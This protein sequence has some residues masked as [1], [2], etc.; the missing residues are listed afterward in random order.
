M[1]SIGIIALD[2]DGT[3]LDSQK[4]LSGRNK[5]ALLRCSDLG[6][7]IVPTTGRAVDGIM[8]EIRNLPGVHYAIT[9][10][11]GTVA[12]LRCARCLTRCT[13]SNVKALEIL[14]IVKKYNAMYD[15]YIDGRGISQP[16]FID[17]MADYGLSGVMQDMVRATRDLV[18][19][20]IRHVEQCKKDVEKVNIYLADL[21]DREILREEL[22]LVEINAEGATKGNA[23]MWLASHLGISRERTMAFGDGENDV[24]ML[25]AAGIGIAMGNGLEIAKRAADQVTLTNDEDGVA[26]AIERLILN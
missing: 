23:L 11:G 10:N 9:T 21:K 24:T 5:E 1:K 15:P 22:S 26:D 20:V 18:S 25:K 16:D 6:I 12:D 17:H 19:D 7:E 3:L 2:L 8:P 14:N 4:R 13:L